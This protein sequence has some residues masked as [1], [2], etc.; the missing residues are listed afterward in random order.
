MLYRLFIAGIMLNNVKVPHRGAPHKYPTMILSYLLTVAYWK[1]INHITYQMNE[2]NMA[3]VCED[4]GELSFS[5]LSRCVLGDHV[6]S[7]V[8]HMDELY[9]LLPIYRTIKNE[10]GSDTSNRNA[11]AWH[12]TIKETSIEVQACAFFFNRLITEVI[13]NT[14]RAYNGEPACYKSRN[15]AG[16]YLTKQF[17]YPVY[18]TNIQDLHIHD[19]LNYVKDTL[20]GFYLHDLRSVWPRLNQPVDVS[21]FTEDDS[22]VGNHTIQSLHSEHSE[23]GAPWNECRVG[24]FCVCRFE[25]GEDNTYCSGL[26]VYQVVEIPD[27][28][29]EIHDY[30]RRFKGRQY[31]C[32][33]MN[34]HVSCLT[35]KWH[36]HPGH[37]SLASDVVAYSVIKYFQSLHDGNLPTNIVQFL[38]ALEDSDEVFTDNRPD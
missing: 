5:I 38:R 17:M 11:L 21:A 37:R 32:T 27:N 20:S 2:Q 3:V 8:Q 18:T 14:F 7:N 25:T 29:D 16:S 33:Q 15:A 1:S 9:K 34:T 19:M 10:M 26:E 12:H 28:E 30:M 13:S 24:S 35:A 22:K 23:W 36:H 4:Y 31:Y 6:K